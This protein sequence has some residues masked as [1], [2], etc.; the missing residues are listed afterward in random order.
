MSRQRCCYA[1][2]I[3]AGP[4]RVG[5]VDR[6]RGDESNATSQRPGTGSVDET[7]FPFVLYPACILPIVATVAS[8]PIDG[9]STSAAN[10]AIIEG[11]LRVRLVAT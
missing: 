5:W 7:P 1:G 2:F 6:R 11:R 9:V 3:L 8:P 4:F 10:I